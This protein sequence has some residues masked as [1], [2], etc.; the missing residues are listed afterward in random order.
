MLI[1][2]CYEKLHCSTD[3]K[4]Y[5]PSDLEKHVTKNSVKKN[6]P[7]MNEELSAKLVPMN[8]GSKANEIGDLL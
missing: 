8:E 4:D 6:R 7:S 3:E 2:F 5:Y 1:C